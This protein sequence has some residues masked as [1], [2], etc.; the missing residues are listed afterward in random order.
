MTLILGFS[1]A[2][3]DVPDAF[4]II[5]NLFS[6][7][8]YIVSN[9]DGN[10][11]GILLDN[12]KLNEKG[13][14][15]L[16]FGVA[17][18]DVKIST[19]PAN[20]SDDFQ[21]LFIFKE[22]DYNCNFRYRINSTDRLLI[23]AKL[24]DKNGELIGIIEDNQFLLNK[25]NYFTW[26]FDLTGFEVI[27]KDFNVVLTFIYDF[28]NTLRF[29]GILRNKDGY[30]VVR[31]DG[32]IFVKKNQVERLNQEIRKIKPVFRYTGENWFGNR[33]LSIN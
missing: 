5:M 18:S 20:Y 19:I 6:P 26:N 22:L 10:V 30:V 9:E 3:V 29:Q 2:I 12:A 11:R 14:I 33:S 28:S 21:C 4:Q 17:D 24:Y 27:D 31:D 13:R 1:S 32:L 25:D 8:K 23:S 15:S 16:S 7:D